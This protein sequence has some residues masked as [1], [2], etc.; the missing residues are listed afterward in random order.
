V[1]DEQVVPEFKEGRFASGLTRGAHALA[2]LAAADAGVTL[3]NLPPGLTAPAPS[4]PAATTEAPGSPLAGLVFLG[5]F[6]GIIVFLIVAAKKGWIKPGAGG[7][8][9][10]SSGRSSGGSSGGFGGGRSG[11]GGAGRSW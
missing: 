1:L 10:G 11:G 9:R 5:L 6:G 2:A 8:G 3:T 4:E 7:G